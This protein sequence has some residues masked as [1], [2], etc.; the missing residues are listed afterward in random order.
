MALPTTREQFKWN[1]L[2]RLG[3]PILEVNVDNDQIE[4]CID[5]AL[6]Y[7]GTISIA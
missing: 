4:D 1:C 2:R 6:I 3:A 5:E 7:F